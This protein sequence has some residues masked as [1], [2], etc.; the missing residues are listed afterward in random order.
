MKNTSKLEKFEK[1]QKSQPCCARTK[2]QYSSIVEKCKTIKQY[3]GRYF[4]VLVKFNNKCNIVSLLF[5]PPIYYNTIKSSQPRQCNEGKLK[6]SA[7]E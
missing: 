2:E 1:L 5:C 3:N 6:K 7:I 4:S